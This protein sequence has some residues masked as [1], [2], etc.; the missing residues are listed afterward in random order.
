MHHIAAMTRN[1][2]A[3]TLRLDPARFSRLAA[4][5]ARQNRTPT[6]YVETLVLRDLAAQEE[7]QRIIT[8]YA[9]PETDDLTPGVLEHG[10]SESDARYAQRKALFDALLSLPDSATRED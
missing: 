7:A 4:A 9:A 3:L 5:A 1:L 8:L 2:K 10:D 6:N